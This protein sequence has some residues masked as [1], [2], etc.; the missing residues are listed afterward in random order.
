MWSGLMIFLLDESKPS[1][2]GFGV[3]L[4]V[5][6]I[7]ANTILLLCFVVQFI[8]A[9]RNENKEEARLAAL[10]AAAPDHKKTDS[11]LSAGFSALR[12]KLGRGG[13][14]VEMTSFINPMQE[15]GV[16]K[17]IKKKKRGKRMKK[18]R[19]KLSIGARVERRSTFNAM[20]GN[21]K[22]EVEEFDSVFVDEATGRRYRYNEQSG[23]AEWVDN[24]EEISVTSGEMNESKNEGR[25]R[26][27]FK[28]VVDEEYGIF[29]EDVQTGEKVWEVPEDA[30]IEENAFQ[31]N[32]MKRKSF[33]RID[34][35]ETGRTYLQNVETNT[36]WEVPE[37]GDVIESTEEIKE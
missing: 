14:D 32:S 15:S 21:A 1:D 23:E 9:K 4:T 8:L 20:A 27:T 35:E 24:D 36:V 13:G 34:D 22:V 19:Q 16:K 11:C 3:I 12:K 26:K 6:V 30:A 29:F 25:T 31:V 2:K 33:K 10:A 5:A 18:V 28:K 7:I 37:D 17:E